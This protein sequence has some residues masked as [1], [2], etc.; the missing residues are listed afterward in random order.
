[1]LTC[2]QNKINGGVESVSNLRPK[3]LFPICGM[4]IGL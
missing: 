1:M 2:F 4:M 3:T